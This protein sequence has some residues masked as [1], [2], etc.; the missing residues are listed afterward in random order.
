[1]GT[2]SVRW[3][4]EGDTPPLRHGTQGR[5]S[6]PTNVHAHVHVH[7]HVHAHAHAHAHVVPYAKHPLEIPP[8]NRF[9]AATTSTDFFSDSVV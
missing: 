2:F 7:V 4:A 9:S 8:F 5:T 3:D 1:V 6:Q